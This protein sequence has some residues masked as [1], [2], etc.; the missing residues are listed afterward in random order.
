MPYRSPFGFPDEHMRLVGIIAAHWEAIDIILQRSV[1]DAIAVPF[2]DVRLLTEN[3]S[4]AAKIDL[5]T[6]KARDILP[7]DQFKDFNKILRLVLTAYGQR[8]AFVHAKWDANGSEPEKPW[9]ISVR[10]KGGRISIIQKPTP[11]D[12]LEAAIERID[13]AFAQLMTLLNKH[14]LLQA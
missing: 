12:E 14:G 9:R 1:A 8:N 2:H 13:E 10:T 7:G 4:V 6:A 3:L 5:L 11:I